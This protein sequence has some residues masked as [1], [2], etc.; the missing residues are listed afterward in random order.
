MAN[1]LITEI[2]ASPSP[3]PMGDK[4]SSGPTV[5]LPLDVK[6]DAN[7]CRFGIFFPRKPSASLNGHTKQHE[8]SLLELLESEG[9]GPR[10]STSTGSK[11]VQSNGAWNPSRQVSFDVLLNGDISISNEN[12]FLAEIAPSPNGV[13][14][15]KRLEF[16]RKLARSLDIAGDLDIW[17]EWI[18]KV[19]S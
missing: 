16:S 11:P 2:V 12:V 10:D 9:E 17:V 1:S 8:L 7:L 3:S 14:D 18:D 15:D 6:F 5:S 19:A 4:L 13:D